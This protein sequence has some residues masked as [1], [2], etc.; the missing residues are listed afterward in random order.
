MLARGGLIGAAGVSATGLPSPWV[1]ADVG[2]PGIAGTSSYAGG[3]FTLNATGN[4]L[5]G[6]SDAFHYVYQPWTG[7]G[8]IVARVVSVEDTGNTPMAG[9]MFRETLDANSRFACLVQRPAN[10][11]FRRRTSVGGTPTTSTS[12]ADTAPT[13]VRVTR[14]GDEFTAHRSENG[15]DWSV[16]GGTITSVMVSS[17]YVGLLCSSN[18]IDDVCTSVI[19]NVSVS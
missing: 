8:V 13:W 1:A 9:V 17:I 16:I 19:D 6:T 15:S 18:E 4:D 2:T 3:E 11:S 7:D 10:L 12:G 5:A 14:S